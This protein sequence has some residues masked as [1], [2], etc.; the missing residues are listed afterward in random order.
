MTY[1]K[2]TDRMN[3]ICYEAAIILSDDDGGRA[4]LLRRFQQVIADTIVEYWERNGGGT[5]DAADVIPDYDVRTMLSA[6]M[7][8]IGIAVS[9]TPT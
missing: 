6:V 3:A 7:V 4:A 1:G 8:N 5:D 9:K 2:M